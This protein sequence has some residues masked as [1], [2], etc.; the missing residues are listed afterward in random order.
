[1][2]IRLTQAAEEDVIRIFH[3][4]AELFGET[5]AERYHRG[6]AKVFDLLAENPELAR[7]RTELT[8]PMR[9]HPHGSHLIVYRA[10]PGAILIVRIRHGREDWQSGNI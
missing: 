1:M 6:L 10:E 4:G 7:E 3:E 5:Q 9:I 2:M 8:P